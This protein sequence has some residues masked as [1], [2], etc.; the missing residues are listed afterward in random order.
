M[1][2]RHGGFKTGE[3]IRLLRR[4]DVALVCADSVDRPLLTDLTSDFAN[5]R[6]HGS[7]ALY[8]GGYDEPALGIWSR[9]ISGWARG[10]VMT[11]RET[12]VDKPVAD[13]RKRDVFVYFD[14]D[15]KL[16]ALFD[17]VACQVKIERARALQ[18]PARVS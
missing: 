8:A 7:E 1:E 12:L 11:D 4:F 2:I 18:H 10:E 9:E 15:A 5:C 6:L 17:A 14:N 3:F 13:R 16:H